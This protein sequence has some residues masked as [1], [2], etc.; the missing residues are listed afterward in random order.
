V[1]PQNVS[2]PETFACVP[3]LKY[4]FSACAVGQHSVR[5][6]IHVSSSS[7]RYCKYA[8]WSKAALSLSSSVAITHTFISLREFQ[9]G[10]A[11]VSYFTRMSIS[12]YHFFF[13]L[14]RELGGRRGEEAC[15]N[16]F[17][18]K[19]RKLHAHFNEFASKIL[20]TRLLL[21]AHAPF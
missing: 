6:G 19:S 4:L 12:I 7:E 9:C 14:E 10:E 8:Y 13:L 16:T 5:R 18:F 1:T 20:K 3:G 17:L 21:S 2:S 11:G 15:R